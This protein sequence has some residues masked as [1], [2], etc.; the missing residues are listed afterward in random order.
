[1]RK[2][3]GAGIAMIFQEPMTSLN[4]VFTVGHQ[5]SEIISL[6]KKVNKKQAWDMGI[7][8][9]KSV[10]IPDPVSRMNNYPFELSG[11][12]R[13]RVMIAM[14]IACDSDI[15]VADEPTTAL[16]VT[17]QAQVIDL[18]MSLVE[19]HNKTLVFITHN[20]GLVTRYT[21]RIYV[22]YA[23]RIIESGATEDLMTNPKHPYTIGLLNSVPKLE[24]KRKERLMPI[25]G[26]PPSLIDLPPVCS[27]LPRC[28]C[29][30]EE[31]KTMQFPELRQ[32]GDN[33][34]YAACHLDVV[35]KL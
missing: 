2:I 31:C 18:M 14:A 15:I 13:Q 35:A 24:E 22:M 20:L 23:G 30:G 33:S 16:D 8:A 6:H 26:L 5:I 29:A 10:D 1:M 12:M 9:L 27:F 11:G 7:S 17:T 32:V 34:H 28:S 4:P 21:E 25:D 19:E 3:R